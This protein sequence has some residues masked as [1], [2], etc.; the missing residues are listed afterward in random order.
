MSRRG[1][2]LILMVEALFGS[3]MIGRSGH[4]LGITR[5]NTSEIPYLN[6]L[7]LTGHYAPQGRAAFFAVAHRRKKHRKR[8]R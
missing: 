4:V 3:S 1:S 7:Y 6:K 2:L 8:Q 5:G